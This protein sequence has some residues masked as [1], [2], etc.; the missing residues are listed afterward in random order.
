MLTSFKILKVKRFY[1]Y[2][3]M[4]N[5]FYLHAKPFKPPLMSQLCASDLSDGT[6]EPMV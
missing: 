6:Y 5:S 2:I 1:C 4:V 3:L